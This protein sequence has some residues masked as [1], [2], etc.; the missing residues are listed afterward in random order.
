MADTKVSA[1]TDIGTLA[2]GDKF[3]VA[4]AS[5]LSVS[6]SATAREI[7]EYVSGYTTQATAAGTTTL[8][9]DST[10]YQFFTGTLA[11]DCVLPDATTLQ[12][13]DAFYID[14]NSTGIVTIKTNGGATLIA[15]QANNDTMV[16]VTDIS[17]SAGTWD[18]NSYADRTAV[19]T[20]TD[21]QTFATGTT[22]KAPINIPAG[23]LKTTPSDGD[24]ESDGDA[25]YACTDAGNRG[26]IPIEHLIRA[27][28]TR[29][30]TSNTSQQAI[31]TTPAN[32]TLTLEV[33]CY[34]FEGLIAMDTMLSLIHI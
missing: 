8:T 6:K 12:L 21:T 22:T 4:D 30:F 15:V 9:V 7:K 14:N 31:F 29:T 23:T 25:M 20:W 17:T 28:A 11:Q 18:T 1:L 13:G 27:D 24:I 19:N 32:G 10:Y 34:L 5:D 3:P 26:V 2:A 33:G 16:K